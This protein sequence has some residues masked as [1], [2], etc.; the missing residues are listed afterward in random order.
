MRSSSEQRFEPRK[1]QRT[2][3]NP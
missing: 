3:W 1:N 2:D